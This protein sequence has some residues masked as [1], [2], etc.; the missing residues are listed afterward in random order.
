MS[1]ELVVVVK[2]NSSINRDGFNISLVAVDGGMHFA[3]RGE[4]HQGG[5]EG[6]SGGG[7]HDGSWEE[8]GE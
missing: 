2:G 1:G 4:Q 7:S 8:S 5:I 3:Q 6:N